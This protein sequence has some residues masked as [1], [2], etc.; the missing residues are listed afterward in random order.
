MLQHHQPCFLVFSSD[1]FCSRSCG[2]S[3]TTGSATFWPA[4][5][6]PIASLYLSVILWKFKVSM[7]AIPKHDLYGAEW[8]ASICKF[9]L[10]VTSWWLLWHMCG[11]MNHPPPLPLPLEPNQSCNGT[12]VGDENND[13]KRN[14]MAA[15]YGA[16]S[17]LRQNYIYIQGHY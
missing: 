2:R 1:S 11:P 3:S 15:L 6:L 4:E 17:L 9:L 13:L 10:S 12:S 14:H 8:E 7:M 5:L 16:M